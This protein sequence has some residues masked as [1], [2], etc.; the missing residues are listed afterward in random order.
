MVKESSAVE[1]VLPPGVFITTTPR[2]VAA[3]TSTLSMPTPAR[4]TTR[5]SG[6]AS[7]TLRVTLVSE[8]T[9][10]ATASVTSGNSSASLKR[11]GNTTT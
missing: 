5:S 2:C 9:T 8:R 7:I 10:I 6:A 1:I 4:P 3:S 11:L